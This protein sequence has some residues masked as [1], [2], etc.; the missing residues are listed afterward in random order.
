MTAATES[1]LRQ[2]SVHIIWE[3]RAVWVAILIY[4]LSSIYYLIWLFLPGSRIGK[5]ASRLFLAGAIVQTATIAMRWMAVG[6]PPYESLYESLQWFA[7]SAAVTYIF[8][9]RRFKGVYIAGFP[10]AV[11]ACAACLYAI[12]GRSPGISPLLP[13]LQS[14]WFIWHV[15]IAFMAYAVFVVAF[16]VEFGYVVLARL[17]PPRMFSRYGMD[18]DTT[19]RF[20]RAAHLLALF[21]FPLLTF[22]IISG[23]AWAEQAWGRYWSWDPKET[24]SLITWTVYALYL[25]AM[26][27]GRWRGGRATALHILGFV[28]MFMTFLG[29]SWIAKLL[30]IPSLH[31][32]S[33]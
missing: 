33:V 12:L 21:G 22:G 31:A 25:H 26:T 5:L 7:W 3:L 11:V 14:D 29:V 4:F 23:A 17:L 2:D 18:A 30:G 27:L 28:C 1:L 32:F 15:V 9:E 20:H 10:V 13:A 16:A 6:R 8:V 19:A 24:W